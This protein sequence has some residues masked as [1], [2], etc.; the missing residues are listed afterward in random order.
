MQRTLDK[1]VAWENSWDIDFSVNKF[2]LLGSIT[3]LAVHAV[4]HHS[5]FEA[6]HI[7]KINSEFQY[8]MN[9]NIIG[10]NQYMKRRILEC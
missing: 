7:R 4:R 3:R 1:L 8:Q 6:M 5:G 10:S 2:D 9:D